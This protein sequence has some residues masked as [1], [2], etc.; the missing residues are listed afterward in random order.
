MAEVIP[1]R[2]RIQAQTLAEIKKIA[3]SNGTAETKAELIIAA[4]DSGLDTLT[5]AADIKVIQE[6]LVNNGILTPDV[7]RVMAQLDN[8]LHNLSNQESEASPVTPEQFSKNRDTE[9]E[10]P[11]VEMVSP[12]AQYEQ[13]RSEIIRDTIRELTEDIKNGKNGSAVDLAKKVARWRGEIDT[14][15]NDLLRTRLNREI[16]DAERVA[17]G[18]TDARRRIG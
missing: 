11:T 18:I 3:I 4:L 8:A 13:D 16:D 7:R 10:L 2:D 5:K 17:T 14:F 6:T 9:P 12:T 15:K 1:I